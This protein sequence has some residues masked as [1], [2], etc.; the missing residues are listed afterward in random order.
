MKQYKNTQYQVYED[1]R[2][3]NI[4]TNRWLKPY[5]RRLKRNNTDRV[6]ISIYINN[7]CRQ[8]FLHRILA[9]CF[10]PNLLNLPHVNHKDGNP[11]NNELSN[12]EWSSVKD[13]NI[14][15]IDTGLRSTKINYTIAE[16]IRED[17]KT[18]TAKQLNIKYNLSFGHIQKI[19]TNQRW[20]RD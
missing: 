8:L 13:N 15:A 2:V 17:Y 16:K 11:L 18:L 10:I 4:I 19:V 20:Q 7:K 14:H 9:E 5:I 3:F 6:L 1:G 12:L